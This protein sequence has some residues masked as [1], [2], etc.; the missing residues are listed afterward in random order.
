MG[1][2]FEDLTYMVDYRDI[3]YPRLE[4]KTATLLLVLPRNYPNEVQILEKHRKW[5]AKKKHVIQAALE[6]SKAKQLNQTRTLSELKN[7]ASTLI[8][9]YQTELSTTV[10]KT[11]Y[12]KMRTKW[13][14]HSRRGNL[15]VNALLRYLPKNLIGYIFYHELT[16]AKHGRKHDREFWKTIGKKFKEYRER[17]NELLVYWF[18]IQ[19][20]ESA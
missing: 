19:K 8:Q 2:K 6:Q 18:L 13:A 5:I 10:K 3:K 12:R 15:T 9:Q 7:L 11:V 20:A 4:F 17:E 16:H 14:S 1:R